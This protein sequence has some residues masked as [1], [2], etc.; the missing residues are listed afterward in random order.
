MK[1]DNLMDYLVELILVGRLTLFHNLKVN[2]DH[3]V[4]LSFRLDGLECNFLDRPK[5]L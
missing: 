3:L 4:D 2:I 5:L 1:S